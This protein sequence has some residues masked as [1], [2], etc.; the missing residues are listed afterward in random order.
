MFWYFIE[1]IIYAGILYYFAKATFAIW[2]KYK[3]AETVKNVSWITLE[4][5]LPREINKSPAAMESALEA[6]YQG[7]G[8][9]TWWDKYRK[10]GMLNR[11]SLEIASIGGS[12]HFFVRTPKRFKNI[13]ESYL[14]AQYSGLE[15]IE[16]EDYT[17]SVRYNPDVHN[18]I[19]SHFVLT[20]E[21][22]LPIKTYTD[23]GLDKDPKEEFKIDPMTP[24][25]EF[26]GSLKGGEQL[27]YQI[28]IRTD[29]FVKWKDEAKEKVASMMMRKPE[30]GKEEA[31]KAFT[32]GKLTQGEKDMIRAI[33]RSTSKNGFEVFV[34]ALYFAP[35]EEYDGTKVT[36]FMGMLKPFGAPNFNGFAPQDD[37]SFLYP[38]QD[39][40]DGRKLK[41][42]KAR[43]FQKFVYRTF[44]QY[45]EVVDSSSLS[46]EINSR[47]DKLLKH[48]VKYFDAK[49]GKNSFIL[50]TEELATLYHFPG[51]V[52]NVP[53][54]KRISSTKSEA[55][56]NLPI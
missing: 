15:I 39:N 33:E 36:S 25:L 24:M 2:L 52:A 14:Y 51:S 40:K 19:G 11:F 4:I 49:K 55:P 12:V 53:T 47:L 9:G 46:Y 43:M 1:T 42:I 41:K 37:T 21:D 38:W 20:K 50:N 23:Y 45:E 8:L 35:K 6:F 26:M 30:A 56:S 29:K 32:E 16:V 17:D 54:F 27:W 10:G 22:F 5:K 28:I 7:G 3:Q 34:R 44:G 48:G 18:M 31:S 13:I